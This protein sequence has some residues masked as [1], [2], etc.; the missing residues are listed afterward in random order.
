MFANKKGISAFVED[1]KN[2]K[3]EDICK[4]RNNKKAKKDT[5]K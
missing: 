4:K 3:G 1:G 2:W 5:A